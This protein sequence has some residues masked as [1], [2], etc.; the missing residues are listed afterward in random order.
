MR[1]PTFRIALAT[2]ALGSWLAAQEGEKPKPP[3]K[4]EP[5]KP[6]PAQT[7]PAA[8]PKEEPLK[9]GAT[10][11][12]TLALTGVD[13]KAFQ[14]EEVRGKVVVIHF[15][16]TDCPWEKAA[17]P[18]IMKLRDDFKDKDVVVLAINANQNEIGAKPAADAFAEKDEAKQPY[19]RLREKSKASK[20][21]HRILVDHGATVAKQFQAKTTPHC[22]VL[23][24]KGVLAYS[25]A[26]DN[27]ASDRL[28]DKAEQ[29]VRRAV[30]ALLAGKKVET[31]TTKPYG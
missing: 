26:L 27:D 21:N 31:D 15:W 3:V 22:F 11:P 9:V 19:S 16:S 18:K 1:S 30:D 14:F 4:P 2:L 28:G 29:Y 6:E 12:G 5:A 23:D 17:E 20:F 24:P 13:G 7:E 10:V 25:G 8:K